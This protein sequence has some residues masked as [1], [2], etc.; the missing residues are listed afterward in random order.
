MQKWNLLS[1]AITGLILG[2][3]NGLRNIKSKGFYREM[4]S[5]LW[6]LWVV[7]STIPLIYPSLRNTYEGDFEYVPIVAMLILTIDIAVVWFLIYIERSNKRYTI[8]CES[9]DHLIESLEG[10]LGKYNIVFVKERIGNETI[11]ISIGDTKAKIRIHEAMISKVKF[12]LDI[13]KYRKVPE[14]EQIIKELEDKIIDRKTYKP[15]LLITRDFVGALVLAALVF[16][17]YKYF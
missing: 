11:E 13:I 6:T 2:F 15:I 8:Y 17:F 1:M 16:V 10:I 7:G 12:T 4:Y 14:F 9:E 3:A 5:P